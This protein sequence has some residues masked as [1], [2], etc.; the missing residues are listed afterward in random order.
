MALLFGIDF[1]IVPTTLTCSLLMPLIFIW[2]P[3]FMLAPHPV[4]HLLPVST[5]MYSPCAPGDFISSLRFRN[6]ATWLYGCVRSTE[7][8]LSY[9]MEAMCRMVRPVVPIDKHCAYMVQT[10]QLVPH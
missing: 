5:S 4:V 7:N 10:V 9:V 8:T 3:P 6:Q 2:C 1:N